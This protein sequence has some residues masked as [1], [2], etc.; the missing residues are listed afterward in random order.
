MDIVWK[1]NKPLFYFQFK[2]VKLNQIWPWE[3]F[4]GTWKYM[5]RVMKPLAISLSPEYYPNFK[6]SEYK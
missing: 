6:Q 2:P 1:R 5:G 4:P 3:N